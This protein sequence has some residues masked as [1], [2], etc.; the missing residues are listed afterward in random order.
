MFDL[1][2]WKQTQFYKDVKLEGK[3]EIVRQLLQ[4][5]MTLAEVVSLTGLSE[6]EL[7]QG[8]STEIK[9]NGQLI[10]EN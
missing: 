8:L 10:T 9:T 4:R 1:T 6:Q 7:Q 2:D 5:G 3:L